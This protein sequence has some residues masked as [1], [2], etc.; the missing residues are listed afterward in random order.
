[1]LVNVI[2]AGI[3]AVVGGLAGFGIYQA[4]ECK[5]KMLD[6]TGYAVLSTAIVTV[7]AMNLL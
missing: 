4:S 6:V 5:M 7:I 3:G 1:M 2:S